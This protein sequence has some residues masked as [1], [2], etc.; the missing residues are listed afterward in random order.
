MAVKVNGK[1]VT[2]EEFRE[3]MKRRL[4]QRKY[5]QQHSKTALGREILK[6]KGIEPIVD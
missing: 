3:L 2:K 1:E 5:I 6:R 4:M